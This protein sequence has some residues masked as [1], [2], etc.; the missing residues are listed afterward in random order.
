MKIVLLTFLPLLVSNWAIMADEDIETQQL[1]YLQ[2][3]LDLEEHNRK[4]DIQ[5]LRASGALASDKSKILILYF[6]IFAQ[7]SLLNA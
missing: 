2:M 6:H 5:N 1:N 4:A 3:D 7:A